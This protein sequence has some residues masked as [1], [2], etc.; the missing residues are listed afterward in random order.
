[1][2]N[3]KPHEKA[4]IGF[5]SNQTDWFSVLDSMDRFMRRVRNTWLNRDIILVR[6]EKKGLG[7]L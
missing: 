3:E 5:Y 7:S 2:K 6:T 4:A 1:M